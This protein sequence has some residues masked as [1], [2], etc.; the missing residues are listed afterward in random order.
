MILKSIFLLFVSAAIFRSFVKL[1]SGNRF[2][3]SPKIKSETRSQVRNED[4]T[5]SNLAFDQVASEK[6]LRS[7]PSKIAEEE[8]I[9]SAKFKFSAK[10]VGESW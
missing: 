8:I 7:G 2:Q 10:D 5:S 4:I 6:P 1:A 9:L 3:F